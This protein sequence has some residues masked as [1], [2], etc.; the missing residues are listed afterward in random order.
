MTKRRKILI[1]C[2][3]GLPIAA[4]LLM[5]ISRAVESSLSPLAFKKIGLVEIT[6]VILGSDPYVKQLRS[7]R[8]DNAIAGV[9]LRVDSPGGAVAPSQEIYSEVMKFRTVK[10]PLVASFGNVAASGGYY[11]ACPAQ[12]IFANPG[13]VTA[14]IGVIFRFPQYYKLLDKLGI[15]MQVLKS[16]DVKD[17]GSAERDMTPREKKL[18]DDILSDIHNQ[19]INDVCRG[20]SLA[21]DS[22]RPIADGRIMTGTQALHAGLVDTLGTYQDAADYLKKYLGLSPDAEIVEKKRHESFL[23]SLIFGELAEKFPILSN[24][25]VPSG[26]YFLCDRPF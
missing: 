1:I 6:D 3:C 22:V 11:V 25:F 19:F 9:L 24:T 17:M 21:P 26:S 10:K 8:E 14:S 20:R 4:G 18:F 23:H 5:L 15:S 12:R 16:G 2:L 7:F 13:T